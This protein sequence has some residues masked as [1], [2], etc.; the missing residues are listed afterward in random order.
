MR[1]NRRQFIGSIGTLAAA[2]AVT[3]GTALAADEG[4]TAGLRV[5]HA[6]PDAPAVDVFVD[7]ERAIEGLSFRSVTEYAELP[8]GDRTVEVTVAGTETAV[9]GP[10]TLSLGAEDYTAVARGEVSS[11]DTGFTVDVFEDTNGANIGDDEVR[12][13]AIH[14]SPDA[15]P[16]DV[17]VNDDTLTVFEEVAYGESSG[18]TVVPAGEYEL[19]VRPATGGEPVFEVTA[20]LAG[21]S[22]YTA[23][24]EGY[25][26][27][28]DEPADEP[29]GLV[30][31]ED[32]SA[33]PRGD[34]EGRGRPDDGDGRGGPGESN[35]R[36]P[37]GD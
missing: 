14:A 13:R 31:T 35:G 26:T 28:D 1:S 19:E 30:L 37:G 2:T 34:G 17:T 21:G 8:A 5:A 23:F 20:S 32:A 24:A 10:T 29:F 25:L 7:G 18:Y 16:V 12:V 22:T 11:D 33:P 27:P 15:P 9:F 3:S 36:G 4:E 6:S